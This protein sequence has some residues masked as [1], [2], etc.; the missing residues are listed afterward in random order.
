MARGENLYASGIVLVTP[1]EVE[2]LEEPES[3][4]VR[5]TVRDA[6]DGALVPKVLVKVIGS[7]NPAF[8]SGP[9]DLRGV[10]VAEGVAGQV[11]AVARKGAGQ[12]A[13]YRGVAR[14]GAST[15]AAPPAASEPKA[16]ESAK[17]GES[18]E[19]NLKIENSTNQGKQ[20]D[21]LLQRYREKPQGVNPF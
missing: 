11:T 17:A 15:P 7:D 6:G 16:D 12:Y 20:I 2:V 3:G 19:K 5:V 18:L 9:T 8:S 4:R 13:F 21:R 1:L 10:F 14:V